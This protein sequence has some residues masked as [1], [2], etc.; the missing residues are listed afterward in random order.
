MSPLVHFGHGDKAHP[1]YFLPRIE[2]VE[3]QHYSVVARR[4]AVQRL[5]RGT[6]ASSAFCFVHFYVSPSSCFT[7]SANCQIT[8]RAF[9]VDLPRAD[10]ASIDG[11]LN[12]SLESCVFCLS[13]VA[14]MGFHELSSHRLS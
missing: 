5:S 6:V 9:F 7:S 10:Q 4:A 14:W 13:I 12:R 1:V 11:V 3:H 8:T 2:N